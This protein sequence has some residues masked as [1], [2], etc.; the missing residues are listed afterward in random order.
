M[1]GLINVWADF[2]EPDQQKIAV[3]NVKWT[4]SD[5]DFIVDYVNLDILLEG[6]HTVT[7][8]GAGKPGLGNY[9]WFELT[10]DPLGTLRPTL[11]PTNPPTLKPSLQP[12]NPPTLKPSLQPTNPPTV[13]DE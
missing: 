4:G 9:D 7:L 13:S 1:W 10:A 5:D 2:G 12:T 11:Q 6:N 3:Y 8:E